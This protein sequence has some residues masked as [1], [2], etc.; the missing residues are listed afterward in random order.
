M[1]AKQRGKKALKQREGETKIGDVAPRSTASSR[2]G[3]DAE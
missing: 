1:Q 3:S 2:G